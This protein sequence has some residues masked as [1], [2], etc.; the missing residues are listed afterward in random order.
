MT[1]RSSNRTWL[2][3]GVAIGILGAG[4][5]GL[6]TMSALAPEPE[7]APPDDATLTVD[8][9]AMKW[10]TGTIAVSGQG[11][12][13]A[14]E[15]VSLQAQ[16]S[17]DVT[18]VSP[19]LEAG[20]FFEKGQHLVTINSDSLGARQS[21]I[22]AQL[23]SARAELKLAETQ[24]ERSRSLLALRAAAQEEVD[25]REA[26]VDAAA[27]RVAQL[28]ASLASVRVDL[29][30]SI[31]K[32]PFYGRVRSETVSVGDVLA[33]GAAFAEIYASDVFEIPIA[34]SENDAALIDGL[35]ASG[36]LD[37]PAT[38]EVNYGGARFEWAG[39]LHRVEAGI[40]ETAR[41]IDL[42]VRVDDPEGKGAPVSQTDVE[43]PPLLLGMFATVML[44]SR[45]LGDF[46]E[47]P[48]EAL[49]PD[50]TVWFVAANEA[51]EGVV[52]VAPARVL[53]TEGAL[54]Y[55]Q[56]DLEPGSDLDVLGT[57]ASR[58]VP[59]ARVSVSRKPEGGPAT[60]DAV[61]LDGG[62]DQ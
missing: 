17:G 3:V 39:R 29:R 35:F 2:W 28:E 46:V 16:V 11:H 9:S 19:S 53:K 44:Q 41:T 21:E 58:V 26:A 43:A 10:R 40:D 59:G 51:D 45:T 42:V 24:A 25:Q 30:R 14:F 52:D 5:A 56:L 6:F 57:A 36:P 54:A 34:L 18:F 31:I 47:L 60:L 37:M 22:E 7:I 32:A 13:S 4:G 62:A 12:V 23:A 55:V 27:A 38:V 48:R 50:N 20:A 33:P 61:Q 1:D 8:T 49:R 15:N